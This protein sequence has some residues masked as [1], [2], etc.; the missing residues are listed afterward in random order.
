M[1]RISHVVIFCVNRQRV[2]GQTVRREAGR[3]LKPSSSAPMWVADIGILRSI[4]QAHAPRAS[5]IKEN[6]MEA[7]YMLFRT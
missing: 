4:L 2:Y 1:D 6:I 7:R 3:P 5:L